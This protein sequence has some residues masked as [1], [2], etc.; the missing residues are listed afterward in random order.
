MRATDALMAEHRVIEQVLNVLEVMARQA[1]GSGV[2][3]TAAACEALDFLRMFADHSHHA[4]EENRLFPR[5]E[6]RG[7]PRNGGPT[8][9]MMYE[10][11]LGRGL[12][13]RMAT[14]I[15]SRS[16]NE[17]AAAA[18]EYVMLLRDHIWKEDHRLFQMAER[19]L[20]A[21]DDDELMNGFAAVEHDHLG[22][23]THE[24][25]LAMATRLADQFGVSSS[26]RVPTKC[27][28]SGHACPVGQHDSGS[29]Q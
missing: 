5:L 13:G 15:E 18:R 23:G 1:E 25:Y 12:L 19:L 26:P 17:F 7:L 4:K 29:A 24:A 8:G 16:A 9:V 20:T 6:A 22:D 14:A 11:E 3:D 27:G 2:L 28:C 10:H 21:N